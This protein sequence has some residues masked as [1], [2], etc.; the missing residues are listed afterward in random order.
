MHESGHIDRPS[1][2]EKYRFQQNAVRIWIVLHALNYWISWQSRNLPISL[3]WSILALLFSGRE[4][5]REFDGLFAPK[6]PDKYPNQD[7]GE[8]IFIQG[9]NPYW[10][11]AQQWKLCNRLSS[12]QDFKRTRSCKPNTYLTCQDVKYVLN[13]PQFSVLLR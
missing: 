13:I 7:I 6:Y 11:N 1:I 12:S 8:A 5:F 10:A 3:I 9:P 2:F 4:D